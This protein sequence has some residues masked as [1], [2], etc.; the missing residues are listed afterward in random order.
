MTPSLKRSAF[1]ATICQMACTTRKLQTLFSRRI[2]SVE[3]MALNFFKNTTLEEDDDSFGT[4]IAP[5]EEISATQAPLAETIDK[6][7]REYPLSM[8]DS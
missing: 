4:I 6:E 5:V 7:M 3:S 8:T 1:Y 2:Q